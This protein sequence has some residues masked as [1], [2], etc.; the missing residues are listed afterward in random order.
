M[1]I[2]DRRNL[3]LRNRHRAESEGKV[4][5]KRPR[6]FQGG[7]EERKEIQK[8]REEPGRKGRRVS[9]SA[10]SEYNDIFLYGN[11]LQV[12]GGF[13]QG[14]GGAG[15]PQ[16]YVGLPHPGE[17]CDL[18]RLLAA[19]S[20]TLSGKC[21]LCPQRCLQHMEP[22]LGGTHLFRDDQPRQYHRDDPYH[23]GN[24]LHTG[25]MRQDMFHS[26]QKLSMKSKRIVRKEA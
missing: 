23:F 18:C 4:G 5:R 3:P 16:P 15:S 14:A 17:L 6:N 21:G 24:T 11:I 19:E 10:T 1:R 2:P 9:V 20:E 13:H 25:P 8:E 7:A 26:W 22:V 12:C